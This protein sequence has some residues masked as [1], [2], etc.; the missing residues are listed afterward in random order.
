MTTYETFDELFSTTNNATVV[1]KN[2]K[3]YSSAI[4]TTLSDVD[5]YFNKQ[6]ITGFYIQGSSSV[7]IRVES[8]TSTT[9]TNKFYARV[10]YYNHT[11]QTKSYATELAIVQGKKVFRIQWDGWESSS[12]SQKTDPYHLVFN[13]AFVETGDIILYTSVKPTSSFYSAAANNGIWINGTQAASFVFNE[14]VPAIKTFTSS[15]S[16]TEVTFAISNTYPVYS[17]NYYLI[18]SQN[19]I[20]T[21]INNVLTEVNEPLSD[22]V[23]TSYGMENQL[24]SYNL[25]SSLINP[26]ILI[27]NNKGVN[28]I[29]ANIKY[30]INSK[31]TIDFSEDAIITTK[32]SF[33][34]KDTLQHTTFTDF[35]QKFKK[36]IVNGSSDIKILIITTTSYTY[37]NHTYSANSYSFKNNNWIIT[38]DLQNDGMSAKIFN[39]ISKEKWL[40]I[41]PNE[42]YLKIFI[43]SKTSYFRNVFIIYD[44]FIRCEDGALLKTTLTPYKNSVKLPIKLS[45]CFDHI[46]I[47]GNFY[48][49]FYL[50]S[51]LRSVFYDFNKPWEINTNAILNSTFFHC[52]NLVNFPTYIKAPELRETFTNCF[53]L[54][55]PSILLNGISTLNCTFN[56][57]INLVNAPTMPNGITDIGGAFH[58][59]INL[60]NVSEIPSSVTSMAGPHLTGAFSNCTSLVNVPTIPNGVIYMSYAFKGCSSIVNTPTIPNSVKYMQ[61]AFQ[62]CE[63][64]KNVSTIPNG[65]LNVA[66]AFARCNNLIN[67]PSIPNS[68][69]SVEGLFSYCRNIDK[70]IIPNSAN[71][72]SLAD[73]YAGWDKLTTPPTIPSQVTNLSGAFGGCGNLTTPPVI[74]S[75]V[76][77]ISEIVE[78]CSKLTTPPT[79]PA[80]VTNMAY[81]FAYCENLTTM[82]TIPNG[83]KIMYMAFASCNN[84]TTPQNIPQSVTNMDATFQYCN[85]LTG[86]IYIHSNEAYID[87]TTFSRW[88]SSNTPILN[89][90]VHAGTN[91]YN[92]LYGAFGSSTYNARYNYYLKTF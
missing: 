57:C 24:P 20:Y 5:F 88:N 29:N 41:F 43:P 79:I 38:E 34:I 1:T 91:T 78:S 8:A 76:T 61:F 16:S 85:K 25:Y 21:V 54:T 56:N 74:P 45:A 80:S 59:C 4:T 7:G 50:F 40:E 49:G 33:F 66:Y 46:S 69:I 87:W 2:V 60:V 72:T 37:D 77:D 44:G 26:E 13:A 32:P 86:N 36:I 75:G 58:N 14:E 65:V 6:K 23:F 82:P 89:I 62:D 11:G 53:N 83:V 68:V 81:A 12:S 30:K 39:N 52:V 55:M 63:N 28:E 31:D 27:Y 90:Y 18:R 35:N 22:S 84:L 67:A 17:T 3:Y 92:N 9:S 48:N 10:S 15:G 71:I 64:L 47:G 70:R 42:Y 51:N 19:K 73:F